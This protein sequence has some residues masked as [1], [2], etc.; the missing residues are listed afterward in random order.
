M[1]KQ[2]T[3]APLFSDEVGQAVRFGERGFS[4]FD[5]LVFVTISAMVA[6][7]ALPVTSRLLERHR[8]ASASQQLKHEI[9]RVRN[10]AVSQNTSV[11]LRFVDQ[12]SY[13][14]EKVK[15]GG[16]IAVG[17]R[18]TLPLGITV[19]GYD[20]TGLLFNRLGISGAVVLLVQSSGAEQSLSVSP[21]GRVTIG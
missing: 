2:D 19:S 5:L 18:Q 11:R 6:A 10:Q 9:S 21:L 4:I 17:S 8:L 16:Y 20:E 7:I 1:I 13:L 12:E 3:N 14:I 15:D